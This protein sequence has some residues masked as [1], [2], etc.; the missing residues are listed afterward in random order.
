MKK[1]QRKAAAV[2]MKNLILP[3]P[4]VIVTITRLGPRRLDDDNLQGAAKAVRDEIAAKIG[5]DDGSALYTWVYRQRTG[6]YGVDV[7]VIPR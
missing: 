3:R 7:E 2:A 1:K 5:T 4:P 6:K